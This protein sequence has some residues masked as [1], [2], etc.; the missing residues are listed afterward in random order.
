MSLEVFKTTALARESAAF[1]AFARDVE[2]AK[3]RYNQGRERLQRGYVGDIDEAVAK[4]RK[5]V[6]APPDAAAATETP[7]TESAA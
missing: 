7:A 5:A 1:T 3:Q 4:M 6:G 2:T